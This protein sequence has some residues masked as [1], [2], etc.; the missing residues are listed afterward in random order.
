MEMHRKCPV[1]PTARKGKPLLLGETRNASPILTASEE[2]NRSILLQAQ[3]N[4]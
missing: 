1:F 4:L 3:G 2:V